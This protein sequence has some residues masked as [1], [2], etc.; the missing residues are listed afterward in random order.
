[1][2]AVVTFLKVNYGQSNSVVAMRVTDVTFFSP[3]ALPELLKTTR[4]C[5]MVPII[6]LSAGVGELH[7]GHRSISTVIHLLRCF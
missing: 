1:M 3:I 7:N 6:I 2:D 5:F 4:L